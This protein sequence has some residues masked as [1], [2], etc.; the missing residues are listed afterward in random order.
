MTPQW[1]RLRDRLFD[2][3]AS[4]PVE[5]RRGQ[6]LSAFILGV[7]AIVGIL[8]VVNTLEWMA[9]LPQGSWAYVAI[10]LMT[11]AVLASL[12]A[13]NRRGQTR[14]AG[15]LFLALLVLGSWAAFGADDIDRVITVYAVPVIAASFVLWPISSFAFAGLAALSY[16]L[17]YGVSGQAFV[18]NYVSMMTLAVLAWVAWLVASRLEQALAT[19]RHSEDQLLQDIAERNRAE[20]ALRASEE[21]FRG[22]VQNLGEG[23]VLVGPDE[24]FNFANAAAETLFGLA[25]GAWHGRHVQEFFSPQ[26]FAIIKQETQ[27]RHLG[28]ASRYELDILRPNGVQR[29]VLF[30]GT[31]QFGA[32]GAFLG[33]LGIFRDVTE[34]IRAEE[35]LRQLNVR[36]ED[37]N[38]ELLVLHQVSRTLAA[39][40]DPD[41]IYRTLYHEVAE[42]MLGVPH[43]V[44]ALFDAETQQI[45]CGF[46]MIDGVEIDPEDFPP[47]PLGSDPFSETILTREGRI[48]DLSDIQPSLAA[49]GGSHVD[50]ERKSQSALYAPLI[51]GDQ[52]IGVLNVQSY[53]RQA[54]GDRQLTLVV[55][56]ASQV[57]VA[58][59]NAQLFAT[60]EQRVAERTASFEA[61][62]QELNREIEERRRIEYIIRDSEM[63]F[64]QIAENIRE[65]FWITSADRQLLYVSPAYE[66]IWGRTCESFY[67]DPGSFIETV[68]PDD[69]AAVLDYFAQQMRGQ[70]AFAEYRILRPDG[71][72]GWIWD[73]AFPVR[74]EAGQVYRITGVAEDV[75]GRKQAEEELHRAL[76]K[77]KE[78]SDLK[79]RFIS[80][81]SHEFRTPLSG[82]LSSAELLEH[83]GHKWPDDKKLRHLRRIQSNV[84]TMTSLL[85]DVLIIG[86]ADAAQTVFNPAR[87]DL[88]R[89]CRD[90]V[91]ELQFNLGQQHPITLISHVPDQTAWLDDKLLRQILANLLSNAV[92][93]SPADTPVEFEVKLDGT[94]VVFRVTDH[95]IGIPPAAEA[96]LFDS[97]YRGDNVGNIPGSGLGLAIVKKSVDLHGGSIRYTTA[98]GQGTTFVVILPIHPSSVQENPYA[99]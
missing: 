47:L 4:D 90:L 46:A 48:V 92:K 78:L 73:R 50:D 96:R 67:Q 80:M 37:T 28:A 57:A 69:R 6:I 31:P 84:K 53:E 77:E 1:R 66:E 35:E 63:R 94:E 24:R 87:L 85:E 33:T 82:I 52:V 86:R 17:S 15:I 27:R 95:G 60:L 89:F 45:Q 59:T 40:L 58:I 14:L 75:T 26:Q 51:T 8:T 32:G 12:W 5:Q 36:L 61:A 70:A 39:T 30:T 54:F 9:G 43:L 88:D 2:A 34:R 99:D 38:H 71:A 20:E 41:E 83:Y 23:V 97:F 81:A 42:R 55:A 10:D 16:T 29:R 74:D 76:A 11:L 19:A 64:R 72:I 91:E 62:N 7:A 44:V 25:P 21:R 65:A 93:Y 13:A 49:Q 68:H 79:S 3:R 98:L 18:Y 56:M 22:L